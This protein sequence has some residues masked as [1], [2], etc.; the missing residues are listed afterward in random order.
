MKKTVY[1]QDA[2][3]IRSHYRLV[4]PKARLVVNFPDFV[5]ELDIRSGT[6]EFTTHVLEDYGAWVTAEV[7]VPK[8]LSPFHEGDVWEFRE[9]AR[10]SNLRLICFN[11]MPEPYLSVNRVQRKEYW[12]LAVYSFRYDD[13]DWFPKPLIMREEY[14]DDFL[15]PL[16]EYLEK[17]LG[18]L[19]QARF[20]SEGG[21][22]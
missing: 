20:T 10:G 9:Q 8:E 15:A 7:L 21:L 12:T 5:S 4:V 11:W 18:H 19:D 17:E 13:R 14:S 3:L 22:Q 2:E 16:K 6:G 1:F